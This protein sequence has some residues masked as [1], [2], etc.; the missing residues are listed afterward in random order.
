MQ[1]FQERNWQSL[2]PP[3]E[4]YQN[5]ASRL[6]NLEISLSRRHKHMKK[7]N[8]L[9]AAISRIEL[10]V[11]LATKNHPDKAKML[12]SLGSRLYDRDHR[13]ENIDDL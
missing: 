8:D 5:Q 4:D 7:M 3:A 2:P 11:S 1:R 10:A 6:Y 13:T 12:S 9:A